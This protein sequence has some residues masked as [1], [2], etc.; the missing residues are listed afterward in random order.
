MNASPQ[1]RI[2]ILLYNQV[3]DSKKYSIYINIYIYIYIERDLIRIES[4]VLLLV[5]S[6]KIFKIYKSFTIEKPYNPVNWT[7]PI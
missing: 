4:P 5:R 7:G 2:Y 1:N 6:I 3:I